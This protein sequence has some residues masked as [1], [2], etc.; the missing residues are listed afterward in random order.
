MTM[1]YLWT[2]WRY[3]YITN[4]DNT[5]RCPFCIDASTHEDDRRLVVHRAGHN[6]VILNMFP[7]TSGHLIIC[8]YQ[9]LANFSDATPAQVGEMMLL[10]Q[11]SKGVLEKCYHPNGFNIG[12]NLGRCAACGAPLARRFQLHD[13]GFG[14]SRPA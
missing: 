3:Q 11:Q 4:I 5:D 14:N 12:M 1:D 13:G 6:F 10:A 7:Y 2:P 9:H 8:P